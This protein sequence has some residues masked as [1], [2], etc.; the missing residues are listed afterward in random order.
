MFFGAKINNLNL[1][2]WN[3][4]RLT[5]MEDTFRDFEG[6]INL[7]NFKT[8][9]V[10]N[11]KGTFGNFKSSTVDISSFSSQSATTATNMFSGSNVV[12]I[13][14]T[15]SFDLTNLYQSHVDEWT[16]FT[17]TTSLVGGNG[18]SC[19][20]AFGDKPYDYYARVDKVGR[21][22]CFTQK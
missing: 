21:P 11:F 22:G 13:Y 3:N 2:G 19:K 16:V 4:P 8:Q 17:S 15:D 12:T 18:T 5:T 6:N 9:H 1:S 7:S 10:T 14:A 20:F